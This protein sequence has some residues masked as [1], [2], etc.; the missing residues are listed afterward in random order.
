MPAVSEPAFV[1]IP[2]WKKLG[3]K[4]KFAEEEPYNASNQENRSSHGVNDKKRKL[5]E[6]SG[7]S[8]PEI[9]ETS[10]STKRVKRTKLEKDGLIVTS[11]GRTA[12][13]DG[14]ALSSVN[15]P[16]TTK[17]NR[18]SVS[19]T[20]ETKT[21]D[22]DGVK[23]LYNNWIERQTVND[24]SFNL[25]TTN[26]ALRPAIPPYAKSDKSTSRLKSNSTGNAPSKLDSLTPKLKKSKSKRSSTTSNVPSPNNHPALAYLT[27][28]HTDPN[29]WKFSKPHQNYLL[30]H[31]FSIPHIPPSYDSAFIGYIRGLQG[32]ARQ[33]IRQQALVIRTEDETW[34][35]SEPG[36][37]EKM[38]QETDAQCIAR[39]KR[40]YE[41][42]LAR[43]K[44]QLED[45]EDKREDIE[46]EMLG[47]KEE[48]E[49]R[50]QKRRRAEVVLWGVGEEE[51]EQEQEQEITQ[52]AVAPP[53]HAGLRNHQHARQ[54]PI[55][56][57]SRGMG[58]VERISNDGI[59][60]DSVAKKIVFDA[61]GTN[62]ADRVGGANGMNGIRNGERI[63]IIHHVGHNKKLRKRKKKKRSGVPD[64]DSTSSESSSSSEDEEEKYPRGKRQPARMKAGRGAD[65]ASSDSS[66]DSESNSD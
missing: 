64:D 24:P 10:R 43:T 29:I 15:T 28:H 4:L 51:E 22:G 40:D 33:R 45:K 35:S 36:D 20:P 62:R 49:E 57:Q 66:S 54:Q 6:S 61:D 8:I 26:P 32:S 55:T 5:A 19:F 17:T 11:E 30:K 47:D 13:V 48:W 50:L 25:A 18:K 46:W 39:R 9:V 56:I 63:D 41:A 7:E 21:R 27:T 59:A 23:K 53:S 31:L 16:D 52:D 42:A 60:R 2:A 37:S 14:E 3:L 65:T 1:H 12:S 34:L 44:Q 38:D 58:G